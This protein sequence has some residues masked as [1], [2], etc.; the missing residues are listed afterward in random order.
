[1]LI[2]VYPQ[3][4]HPQ[5]PE[6]G[7]MSQYLDKLEIGSF[8]DIKGPNGRIE[9][10][11]KGKFKI[12]QHHIQTA[13]IAMIAGGTG[14]TPMY[15]ILQHILKTRQP[16]KD[17]TKLSL[18]YGNQRPSDIMLREELDEMASHH[19]GQFSLHYTVDRI[20]SSN[21]TWKGFTGF[22]N[23][24]IINACIP[25]PSD[26]LLV[27]ICGPPPMVRSVEAHLKDMGYAKNRIGVF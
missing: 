13:H 24:E 12:G 7:W 27:L 25:R 26:K 17:R 10:L 6:G 22:V 5:F 2:K 23:P 15:Q 1:L 9:Y 21:E 16:Y 20:D 19:P 11:E 4:Q 3:N 18:I 8:V 14:I